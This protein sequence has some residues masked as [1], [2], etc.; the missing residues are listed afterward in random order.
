[1]SKVHEVE[2]L[3]PDYNRLLED[4][5]RIDDKPKGKYPDVQLLI[6]WKEA[7]KGEDGVLR[8]TSWECR[9]GVRIIFK[10]KSAAD[11]LLLKVATKRETGY[12]EGGGKH[13]SELRSL[14]P[15]IIPTGR[16]DSSANSMTPESEASETDD[17]DKDEV[18]EEDEEEK[19]KKEKERKKKERKE[20]ERKKKE[21]EKKETKEEE[22][23]KKGE[24]KNERKKNDKEAKRAALK[25]VEELFR[26]R[27]NIEDDTKLTEIQ[28]G[29]MFKVFGAFWA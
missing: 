5:V 28:E 13:S 26:L 8:L 17:N 4:L 18:N 1:M 9:S 7:W 14:S 23:K 27:K 19:A 25:E 6:Q 20:K 2:T 22:K 12:R 11:A 29:Q 21:T 3:P 15:D 10:K 24:E 16:R